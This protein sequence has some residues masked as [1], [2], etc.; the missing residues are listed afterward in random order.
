MFSS[1]A[2]L[3]MLLASVDDWVALPNS[4]LFL[5]SEITRTSNRAIGLPVVDSIRTVLVS[6]KHVIDGL[7]E[8]ST[9]GGAVGCNE[10]WTDG[11]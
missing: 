10:G 6:A 9:E 3:A 2:L 5:P 4:A 1:T 7:V 11:V 8:G